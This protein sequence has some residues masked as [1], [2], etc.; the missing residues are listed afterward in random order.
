LAIVDHVTSPTARLLPVA[1]V[2][3]ALHELGVTVYV[4]GAHAPGMLPVEVSAIGADFWVGNLHKWAFA[5]RPTAAFVVTPQWRERVVPL[6][7]SWEQEAGFPAAVEFGGTLDY[8]AWLAAPTGVH[9][10]RTL[11]PERLRQHNVS[12]AEYG[13]RV[14]GAALG[15]EP[16]QLPLRGSPVSMRL[17][18]LPDHLDEAAARDLHRRLAAEHRIEVALTAWPGGRALRVSAQVYNRPADYD[19]LAGAVATLTRGWSGSRAA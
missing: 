3:A 10:L 9:L 17:I 12:L 4:D 6:V 5:P 15:L 8:T 7:V 1:R 2:T 13:Q 16:A 19:R 11:G 14:V 18:P